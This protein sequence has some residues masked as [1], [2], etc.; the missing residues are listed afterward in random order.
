MFLVE[1]TNAESESLEIR[2]ENLNFN[3]II[4]LFSLLEFVEHWVPMNVQFPLVCILSYQWDQWLPEES[5]L[6][7]ICL[8]YTGRVISN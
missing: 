8:L 5:F 2:H 3:E 4:Y 7:L 6:L 1:N